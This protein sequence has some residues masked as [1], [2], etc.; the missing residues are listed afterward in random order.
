[1]A[2]GEGSGEQAGAQARGCGRISCNRGTGP[3]QETWVPVPVEA[4]NLPSVGGQVT[5]P[6]VAFQSISIFNKV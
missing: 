1:M 4:R 3:S 6:A 5:S 2:V